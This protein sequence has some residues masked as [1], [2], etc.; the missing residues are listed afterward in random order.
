MSVNNINSYAYNALTAKNW[1]LDVNMG[2]SQS[3]K[4]QASTSGST[5]KSAS[6]Y[7]NSYTS[8]NSLAGALTGVLDDMGLSSSDKIT[9]QTLMDYRN[10]LEDK[11]VEDLKAGLEKAGIDPEASFRLVSGS[12]GSGVQVITDHADKEKIEKYF[13]DNPGM[14]TKFEQIQSLNKMEET[15][16]TN[17]I[18]PK[19]IADRIRLESMTAWYSDNSSFMSY[20]QQSASFYSGVNLI[21]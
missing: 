21:A 1:G 12:N 20:A 16:Q 13:A 11:F 8:L 4:S 9:F 14:V 5:T 3:A 17:N 6:A 7:A 18:D 10:Q 15:R 19:A 2:E